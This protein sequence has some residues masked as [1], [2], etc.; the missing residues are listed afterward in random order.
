MALCCWIELSSDEMGEVS[1]CE[2]QQWKDY[3]HQHES[4]CD[5]IVALVILES[6]ITIREW[7]VAHF[8]NSV[9]DIEGGIGKLL[10]Q[11]KGP[12]LCLC[13]EMKKKDDL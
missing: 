4:H 6:S 3:K 11:V 7:K 12:G 1:D 9:R 8:V 5:L 10:Q 13:L 2:K